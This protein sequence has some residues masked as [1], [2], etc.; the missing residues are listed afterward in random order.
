M[1]FCAYDIITDV[2]ALPVIVFF[3]CFYNVKYTYTTSISINFPVK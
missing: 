1:N 2:H 3:L